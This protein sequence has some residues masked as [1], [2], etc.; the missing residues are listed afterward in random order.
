M[1]ILCPTFGYCTNYK[2]KPGD[3]LCF[4]GGYCKITFNKTNVY[5]VTL[6]QV[7]HIELY[8]LYKREVTI[9]IKQN[10]YVLMQIS[11]LS[12]LFLNVQKMENM[13]SM[14]LFMPKKPK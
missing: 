12:K 5:S 6:I 8:V 4:K 14:P 10:L 1:L 13:N 7:F 2:K 9:A 3:I 11:H